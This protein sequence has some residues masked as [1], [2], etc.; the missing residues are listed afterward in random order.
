MKSR[1]ERSVE[2]MIVVL[3]SSFCV[4][5]ISQIIG[6]SIFSTSIYWSDEFSRYCFIWVILLASGIA[7]KRKAHVGFDL[8]VSKLPVKLQNYIY[9]LNDVMVGVFLFLFFYNG[10]DLV[11]SVGLTPSPAMM[12]PMGFVYSILPLS[13][14]VMF[15]FLVD[16][17]WQTIRNWNRETLNV[18]DE[19]MNT[20]EGN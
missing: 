7:I 4:T 5:M 12:I 9:I 19:D 13:A 17:V 16:S 2:W 14:V 10:M 3:F 8:I 1:F 15:I 11:T 20:Q 6:R 18:I